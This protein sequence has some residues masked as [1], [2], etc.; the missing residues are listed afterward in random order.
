MLDE[1]ESINNKPINIKKRLVVC[2][3]GT[4][5]QLEQVYPTNV[6]KFA[7]SIKK[8]DNKH[9][10]PQIVF[11]LSGCG[12]GE[13]D[14]LIERL[15]GGAFGWGIDRIIH[16][17]YRFLCMNY[18]P[19]SEDEIYLVGFSRGAYIVRC[20][21]G[22]IYKC[23][24]LERSKIRDIP[25]AY[26]FYRNSNIKPS[27]FE[28]KKF[29]IENAIDVNKNAK[30]DYLKYRVK[31]KMLACW[32]TVGSLGIPDLIPWLQISKIWNKRYEFFD[33]T[34]SPIVENAFH[35]VAIDEKHKCFPS[36][37][38][39]KNNKNCHQVVKEV[40][41]AG[42]HGCIGGG[43]EKYQGLSDYSLEWIKKEAAKL[44]L[45]FDSNSKDNDF[46]VIQDHTTP[47]DNSV[48]GILALGGEEWRAITHSQIFIHSSVIKRLK[49]CPDYRPQNL[50]LKWILSLVR[51]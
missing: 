14:L 18:N 38:M 33:A 31:I 11:Y 4:W 16:D 5:N 15:G 3:D 42:E 36:T 30:E 23:G 40:F 8:M 32:D 12:T 10:I 2:C 45:R 48:R 50:D 35:A 7:R 20:L 27:D 44:G 41:F 39:E 43:T 19:D 51:D 13:G 49:D 37:P 1:R 24:L 9:G 25:K 26:R 6:V 22:M 28:A 29:R 17:A 47:F 46:K 34:L 21:A